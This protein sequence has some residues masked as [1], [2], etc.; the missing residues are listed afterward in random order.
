MGTKEMYDKY[1]DRTTTLGV[2]LDKCIKG[3][4]DRANLGSDWNAGKVGIL[5]GDAES[6][7]LFEELMH[8]TILE[9]HG[10]TDAALPHPPPNLD[11]S[12]LLDHGPPRVDDDQDPACDQGAQ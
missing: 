7:T 6:V 11:G 10:L 2:T 1:K 12:K 3:G 9:R 8:P 5:F 4:V